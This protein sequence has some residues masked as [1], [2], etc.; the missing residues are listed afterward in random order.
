MT[1]MSIRIA[2]AALAA[3][4]LLV[5]A[6]ATAAD[7]D[8][9][10]RSQAL[11]SRLQAMGHG[12]YTEAEWSAVTD[13]VQSLVS[14]ARDS[15]DA[16]AIIRA[17]VIEASVA[18]DMRHQYPTALKVVRDARATL[19]ASA[20]DADLSR[21]YVKEAELLAET[22]DRAAIQKLIADYQ[23]SPSYRPEM[24]KWYGGEGPGD[25]LYIARPKSTGTA[26]MPLS[27]M[28]MALRR[29]GSAAGTQFPEFTMTDI[30]GR[31]LS[32]A[33]YRG[34]V[35]LVDFFVR[36]WH[37][38]EANLP[39]QIDLFNRQHDKGFEIIGVC[40]Q[41]DAAAL[42]D[43]HL[44][45]PVVVADNGLARQLSIFGQSTSYLLDVNGAVLGRD[46][47]GQDLS[48]SVDTA[49]KAVNR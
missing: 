46:L 41:R 30:Y 38:W 5:P 12:V 15:G 39:A 17:S 23:K 42:A 33:A 35:V 49:L 21:L 24:Y 8:F 28:E 10:A 14:A 22:G 27:V 3:C 26:S 7:A 40:L 29:A 16:D 37:L 13:E 4:A 6:A 31:T 25:P 18:G 32:S 2:L 20:P 9:E 11:L 34:R 36:G 19:A 44:P 47:R 45:W 43:L 1:R 48:Y